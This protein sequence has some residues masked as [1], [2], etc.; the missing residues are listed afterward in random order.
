MELQANL[1][2]MADELGADF[3]GI[4]D[5]SPAQEA[6]AKH[7][8]KV[9]AEFPRAISFG[10]ALPHDIVDQQPN[11]FSSNVALNYNHHA[12][13][14]INQRLDHI[15]SRL[16]SVL[17]KEG[18]RSMPIPATQEIIYN[19][20]LYGIFSH[21]M[22]AR[23]AGLGWIGKCCLL[24]TPNVGPRVRWGSVLTDAPL[25]ATEKLMK[26]GCGD[27]HECV[28]ICPTKAFTGEPFRAEDPREIRYN[29][30]KCDEYLSKL[31]KTSAIGVCGMCLY[32]CPYGKNRINNR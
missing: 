24:V 14:I 22:T 28:D 23:F 29:A 12:Y 2:K 5:L 18:N 21:K 4:A 11:R 27:C 9:A 25:K 7:W 17:Q 8:E 19:E 10:I 3:L 31:E 30:H 6:I 32:V 20:A 16:S 1:N 26:D 13:D 15:A